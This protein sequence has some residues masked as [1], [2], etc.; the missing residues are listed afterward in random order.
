MAGLL[1]VLSV[2]VAAFVATNI[3]DLFILMLFFSK[4]SFPRYH[5]IIG[6]YVGMGFL[7]GVSLA[8]S[9]IALV[10]PHNLIG[11]IGFIPIAIGIKELVELRKRGYVDYDGNT[12]I[13]KHLS[14]NRWASY[15]PFLTVATITF[16]GGEEI[17]VYTS[18][19][20]I[21]NSLPETF[22]VISVVMI[23]TGFWCA[24][25]AYLVNHTLIAARFRRIA[26]EALPFVLIALGIYVLIEAFLL[27]T[28][29]KSTLIIQEAF[30][31]SPWL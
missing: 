19:F 18:V 28:A 12:K 29:V 30:R 23:L 25:A 24:I 1:E 8:G 22:T 7:I 21:Y 15:L 16:S 6:Q 13:A 26:D 27:D 10:I 2:A 3:D 5:I 14:R 9:L 11:L 31:P 4:Q 17:G 20:A